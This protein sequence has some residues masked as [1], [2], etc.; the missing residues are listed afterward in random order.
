MPYVSTG[1]TIPVVLESKENGREHREDEVVYED[2]DASDSDN[3]S[4]VHSYIGISIS[5][6]VVNNGNIIFNDD[7]II[8]SDENIGDGLSEIDIHDDIDASSNANSYVCPNADSDTD[9]EHDVYDY[10]LLLLIGGE[11]VEQPIYLYCCST[12]YPTPEEK[13]N[14]LYS[15]LVSYIDIVHTIKDY[16][17]HGVD[18]NDDLDSYYDSIE[19]PYNIT[20]DIKTWIRDMIIDDIVP[21]LR[22]E[23]KF[24]IAF[25]SCIRKYT[26]TEISHAVQPICTDVI[27]FDTD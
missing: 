2:S 7:C 24:G 23:F 10:E 15:M 11:Y 25:L 12:C 26:C 6:S 22:E 18:I 5:D 1:Y 21:E 3:H 16:C 19:C 8:F 13:A 17:D 9:E 20:D 4:S 14:K 27:E